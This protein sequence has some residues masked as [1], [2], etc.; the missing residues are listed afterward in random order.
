MKTTFFLLMLAIS[1]TTLAQ[2]KN[3]SINPIVGSWKISNQ[4][5]M[6]D[7]QKVFDQN[8]SGN[9]QTELLTFEFNNKFKHEFMDGNG[10]VLKTLKGKWKAAGSKIKI[11][12]SDIEYNLTVDYF[13]LEKD[14][15]LGQNFNHVIFT[16][17]EL[18]NIKT[19]MK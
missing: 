7:F 15:V 11:D 16:K 10:N 1:L 4:S 2:R 3:Q 13:F 19:T 12:Y 5:K 8:Q 18:D 17:D 9:I 14:L 6:N